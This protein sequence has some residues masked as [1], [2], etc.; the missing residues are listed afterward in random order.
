MAEPR[1][2]P[3]FQACELCGAPVYSNGKIFH[4]ADCPVVERPAIGAEHT[5]TTYKPLGE[6]GFTACWDQVVIIEDSFRSG[7]ECAKCKGSG[8][9]HCEECAA[10]FS[11][12]NNFVKCKECDG[13]T[14]RT[15]A[16][17]G[18]KG[19][20]IIIPD[21]AQRR[22]TTGEIVSAGEKCVRFKEGQSV[23]F[24]NFAGHAVK[25]AHGKEEIVLRFLHETEIICQMSGLLTMRTH[26]DFVE[27]TT[28]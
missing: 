16:D 1:A 14:W 26:K 20:T 4:A 24:S 19:A 10:G 7:Y 6:V 23:L 28:I 27:M 2:V 5:P 13:T 25:L 22:P 3:T 9:L 17:C 12:I 18:G 21:A 15:C 11:K 8:K